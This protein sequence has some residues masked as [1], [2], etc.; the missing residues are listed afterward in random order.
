VAAPVG[1]RHVA[2]HP[3]NVGKEEPEVAAGAAP[4]ALPLSLINSNMSREALL[5]RES[6]HAMHVP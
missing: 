1:R 2:G 5:A 4:N 3:H 6:I